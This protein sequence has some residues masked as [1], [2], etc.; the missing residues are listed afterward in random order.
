M[1]PAEV[2]QLRKLRPRQDV[3][4]FG[5]ARADIAEPE[6]AA[7]VEGEAPRVAQA[8]RDHLPRRG[9]ALRID[10]QQLPEV[11]RQVLALVVGI[12]VR[13]RLGRSAVAHADVQPPLRVE[14]E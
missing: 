14:R 13:A 10:T 5:A 6:I 9:G 4:L 3:A 8:V 7:A 11:A 12:V 2:R 1:T